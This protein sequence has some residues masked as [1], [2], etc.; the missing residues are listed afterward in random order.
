MAKALFTG[1]DATTLQ[2]DQDLEL[3]KEEMTAIIQKDTRET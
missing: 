3:N 1:R 2:M